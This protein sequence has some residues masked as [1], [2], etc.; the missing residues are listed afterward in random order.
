MQPSDT[1]HRRWLALVLM[2]LL[3]PAALANAQFSDAAGSRDGGTVYVKFER[4]TARAIQLQETG[5]V[6][7][8]GIPAVDRLNRQFNATRMTRVFRPAG[9]FEAR[10]VAHDLDLWYEVEVGGGVDVAQAASA[11]NNLGGVRMAEPKLEKRLVASAE[12]VVATDDPH[13]DLQWHYDNEGQTGGTAGADISLSGAHM[14]EAGRP[15]V[16]VHMMDSGVDLDHPDLVNRLWMNPGEIPGNGIDDD[17]NGYIDDVYGWNFV[18]NNP[19]VEDTDGHGT[20]TSGTVAAENNNGIGVAGVAGGT[21]PSD[22]VRLLTTTGLGEPE[23]YVYA[24]DMG[25][26]ISQNS[27]G[28]IFEGSFEQVVLDA[29]DYFIAEAGSEPDSPM[30]GGLVI[31]AAGNDNDDGNWYPG[32][33]ESTLAV[34]STDFNDV[35]SNYSN[36][37]SWVD[38]TAPGGDGFPYEVGPDVYSTLPGGYGP[39]SGTSMSAPHVSGV[40]AL[41][42]SNAINKGETVTNEQVRQI[43]LNSADDIDHLNPAFEG[44]LGAGRLNALRALQ[45]ASDDVPPAA[46]TDLAVADVGSSF[47]EVTWTAPGDDGNEGTASSYDMRI[48]TSPINDG[49]FE[50]ADPVANLP[51]PS[52][53]GSMEVVYISG[54]DPATT[55][56]LAIR[57]NDDNFNDSDLSNVVEVT[58]LAAP[59][60]AVA[61]SSFSA[62][63]QTGGTETQQLTVSNAASSE[64]TLEYTIVP[65]FISVPAPALSNTRS[66][67]AQAVERFSAFKADRAPQHSYGAVFGLNDDQARAWKRAQA[68]R[69]VVRL[70]ERG[71]APTNVADR[72]VDEDFESGVLPDGWTRTSNGVG[73]QIGDNLGSSFFDIPSHTTYAATNDDAPGSGNDGSDDYLITPALNLVGYSAAVLR[74]QSYFTGE[75]GQLAFI[76]VSVDGG[77]T[78][79]V[80]ASP[81]PALE[82]VETTVVL[83][84]YVGNPDVRVAFHSDD[85]GSWASGWAI[86]DVTLDAYLVGW[87]TV[88]P[89]EGVLDDGE[90]AEH[91]VVFDASG[92][93]GGTYA[94]DV[95][96]FS[97][98]PANPVVSIP[99]T[100]EVE[101]M[102]AIGGDIPEEIDFGSI[103]TGDIARES[104]TIRNAGTATL[105]V[106]SLSIDDPAFSVDPASASLEP[107]ERLTVEVTFNPESEG[108]Y[109]GTLTLETNDANASVITVA[110][111][112]SATPAPVMIVDRDEVDATLEIGQTQQELITVSNEGGTDLEYTVRVQE[113]TGIDL[114]FTKSDIAARTSSMRPIETEAL[115]AQRRY[116]GPSETGTRPYQAGDAIYTLDDGTSENALGLTS[117]GDIM[118]L[119]AFQVI[120]GAETIRSIDVAWGNTGSSDVPSGHP[121]RVFIYNDPNNDGDPTDAVMLTE[122][123]TEVQNPHT[124]QFTRVYL[125]DTPVEGVFFV[126]A[127]YQNHVAN[128][129]P[130]PM[131]QSSTPQGAS[132]VVGESVPGGFDTANLGNNDLAPTNIDAA[133]F[134]GNW[135]LRADVTT[136]S[137]IGWLAVNPGEGT[138]APGGSDELEVTFDAEGVDVGTYTA[139]IVISSNDPVNSP[140]VVQASLFV[141]SAPYPF[142][143]DPES[144]ELTLETDEMTTEEMT[145]TNTT[146]SRQSFR[147]EIRG[148]SG[149]GPDLTNSLPEFERRLMAKVMESLSKQVTATAPTAARDP[150]SGSVQLPESLVRLLEDTGVTAYSSSISGFGDFFEQFVAF[151]LGTPAAM[152]PFGT[153]PN[154]YAG[155]FALD[156]EATFYA[157]NDAGMLLTVDVETGATTPIGTLAPAGETFTELATDPTDGT[158][159]VSSATDLYRLDPSTATT[160]HVGSFGLSSLGIMIAIA[161]DDEGQMWGHEIS[162]DVIYRIDKESG[163]TTLVGP[164]GVDA[165]FAQGMDFD[166][167]TGEL[168][169][170]WYQGSGVG[171]LRVVDRETGASQ[172]VGPFQGDELGYLAIP[173][174][175]FLF[176]DIDL[177]SGT[178]APHGSVTLDLEI[179]ATD[180]YAGTYTAEVVVI[181][182]VAGEPQDVIPVTLTVLA[183]PEIA[184]NPDEIDFGEEFVNGET[185]ETLTVTNTGR[186][187]LNVSSVTLDG[188]GFHLDPDAET[189]FSLEPNASRSFEV[190][191]A[192][193]SVGSFS[194]SVTIASDAPSGDAVVSLTGEGIPAP[195]VSVDPESFSLQAYVGQTYERTL[196]ITN[197]GGSPL[198][199]AIVEE[200]VEQTGTTAIYDNVLLTED[201]EEGSMPD[202]WNATSNGQGWQIDDDLS[203]LF[204][205]IP[206][207]TVY[208]GVND[209]D[210]GSGNDGSEDYLI[211]P[212]MDFSNVSMPMLQFA[213]FYTGQFSQLAWVRVSTDGGTSW[214]LLHQMTAA[215]EWTSVSLDLSDYAGEADVRVAFH[216]DDAGAWASGWA[217]DD[218]MIFERFEWFTFSEC[219]TVEPGESHDVTLNFDAQGLAPGT[220]QVNLVVNTNDPVTPQ[221]T[222]PIEVTVISEVTLAVDTDLMQI[223]EP[224]PDDRVHPG[225][226]I[227]LPVTITSLRDL[228][229]ESFQFTMDYDP[230][231]LQFEELVTEGTIGDDVQMVTNLTEPGSLHIA[232]IEVPNG[233]L[234]IKPAAIEGDGIILYVRFSVLA[235]E[236]GSTQVN[237]VDAL[238]NEG[239]PPVGVEAGTID[240]VPLYGDAS[241]NVVVNAFDVSTVM[242]RVVHLV[243]DEDWTPAAEAAAD[244]SGNGEVNAFDAALILQYVVGM[245]DCFPADDACEDDAMV[246]KASKTGGAAAM[247]A[248]DAAYAAVKLGAMR[249]V[250]GQEN[251]S[252]PVS[253]DNVEGDVRSVTMTLTFDPAVTAVDGVTSALPDGWQLVSNIVDGEIHVALVGSTPLVEGDIAELTVRRL[254]PNADINIAGTMRFNES[255]VRTMEQMTLEVIPAEFTLH[256][257]YPNPFGP[258]T[259]V[260]FDLP[261]DAEVSLEVY[262]VIGRRVM[263]IRSVEIPA[264]SNK[265]IDIDAGSL[266]SGM[267]V[268]RLVV[269]TESGKISESGKMVLVR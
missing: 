196:T 117:G 223:L 179:D 248:S 261:E 45:D 209:D 205:T 40:A 194:G 76:E 198:E 20:H 82:W 99:A 153:S 249:E 66:R 100:L 15:E 150:E 187:V 89:E 168:Y 176:M 146:D 80:I 46:I 134:P 190:T 239:A 233:T 34:G 140:A 10:H 171:G 177:I 203:S 41:I 175:G 106:T 3:L 59:E 243:D 169:L 135:M 174:R 267:Y 204:F 235:E 11:Y 266:A 62:S 2:W 72:L 79:D 91:D 73:W 32:F 166:P 154:M 105:E 60:I 141:T 74:F 231:Y 193:L 133:G 246:A 6:A 244:V 86:D 215:A 19:N 197:E 253:I 54:L 83:D 172:L 102:A 47:L 78:W 88:N 263:D 234:T 18:N 216:A 16:I 33:Y 93:T 55:Y 183:D 5:G 251:L 259:T 37:G 157:V 155:D 39:L 200:G 165:N 69:P 137:N 13:Y 212:S 24:A 48:S 27:W 96:V 38:I 258:R 124:D 184:V 51:K 29:I 221:V 85:A 35:R 189:S 185:T 260:A 188:E 84:D 4:A 227:L 121:T 81:T 94:V 142:D 129:F 107:G 21:N 90:T 36:Y 123:V 265:S 255:D 120:E 167:I 250:S 149:E 173:S 147:I 115:A 52:P 191:F 126:A 109:T 213:S 218:V 111:S 241:L 42:I 224:N 161:I 222:V 9:R 143:L 178:L 95:E 225:S 104:F 57:T 211:T 164:T 264:G 114:T 245:I 65:D 226:E 61:E 262:D 237:L 56:Y 242:R 116:D 148:A 71:V 236:I 8:A 156:N 151:D 269:Q 210:A 206:P 28:Y 131:D 132:W 103:I 7:V 113:T 23:G 252:V 207:H 97:N 217:I 50:D 110:L 128:Q 130:A 229:V 145:I 30:T 247:V 43:L 158:M 201:F 195:V 44:L 163:Q 182:D 77:D 22:G 144:I 1:G 159:F 160:T 186:D 101:A 192:P 58:T 170:A 180:M 240:I 181:A 228:E 268:Y 108:D 162:D 238:L 122:A 256:G 31:F 12:A 87:L 49:N 232:A 98:D 112:G 17:G 70:T 208:A 75:F 254:Q 26:V 230:S 125:E 68:Q 220:Y 67:A 63:L 139:D 202:G 199:C 152:Q 119:N 219:E 118:W 257:N 136:S 127:L 138:V 214:E 14:I 53:A 92:M 25:A 64:S